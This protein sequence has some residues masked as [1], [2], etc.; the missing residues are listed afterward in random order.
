MTLNEYQTE[1]MRTAHEDNLLL[2]GVM[3]LN[4]KGRYIGI[5]KTFK[6]K[7]TPCQTM[8]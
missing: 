3:G 8:L 2:N 6:A 4:A 7:Q 1:A 5:A